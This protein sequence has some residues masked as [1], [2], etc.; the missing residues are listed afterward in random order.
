MVAAFFDGLVGETKRLPE[1]LGPPP[2]Y[3][4]PVWGGTRWPS[5]GLFQ[6]QTCLAM[7]SMSQTLGLVSEGCFAVKSMIR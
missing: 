6:V 2:L 4:C 1:N 7:P 3:V 5:L